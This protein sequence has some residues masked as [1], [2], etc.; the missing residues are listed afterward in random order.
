[1]KGIKAAIICLTGFMVITFVPS[2]SSPSY[3]AKGGGVRMSAP[4]SKALPTAPQKTSPNTNSSAKG[5][6]TTGAQSQTGQPKTDTQA[7]TQAKTNQTGSAWGGTMRNI[8]LLAGGMFLG[9]MLSSLFGW[10]NMGFMAD[11]LGVLFNVVL[12]MVVVSLGMSLW[13][14]FRNRRSSSRNDDAYRR[15]YEEAMREKERRETYTI[16]ITP[17]DDDRKYKK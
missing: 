10:G 12:V 9:S 7:G 17:S 2:M 5:T 4:A 13:R 14:K 8:G 11:I 16:D 1:M 6:G 3:A 15:G